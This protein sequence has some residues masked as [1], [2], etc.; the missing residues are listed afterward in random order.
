MIHKPFVVSSSDRFCYGVPVSSTGSLWDGF[1]GWLVRV[2]AGLL[3]EPVHRQPRATHT[4]CRVI[5]PG[6]DWQG[7]RYPSQVCQIRLLKGPL[8]CPQT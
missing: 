3:L 4:V 5:Q 6:S 2:C 8:S 7:R 1:G